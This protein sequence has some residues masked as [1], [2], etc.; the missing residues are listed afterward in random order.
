[1][2]PIKKKFPNKISL[3]QRIKL[4]ELFAAPLKSDFLKN[5]FLSQTISFRLQTISVFASSSIVLHQ[6]SS[7]VESREESAREEENLNF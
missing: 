6:I 1:M 4:L 5:P 3:R 2:I 7:L